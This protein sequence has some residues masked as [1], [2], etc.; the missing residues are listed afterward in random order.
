MTAADSWVDVKG[1]GWLIDGNTG[2]HSSA[3]GFQT[4]QILS[5]WGTGNVFANNTAVVDGPGYGFHITRPLGNIL[6]CSN[7]V[8]AARAGV[9]N[10]TCSA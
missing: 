7:T 1:N 4:H 2:R 10:I 3:D 8:T 5:G 6:K 9:S